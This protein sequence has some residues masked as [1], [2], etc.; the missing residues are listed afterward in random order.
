MLVARINPIIRSMNEEDLESIVQ[1]QAEAYSG[2]FLESSDVIATRFA[3]N[4]P[5]S[6]IAEV[7]GKPAAYLVSYFSLL[8]KINPLN[9]NF[10]MVDQPDCLYIHDLAILPS[11]QGMGIARYLLNVAQKLA[12]DNS[13]KNI[14]L[15]SVQNTRLF[16]GRLGF[17][18]VDNISSDQQKILKA[19]CD[20][21]QE[22]FYM[23][24]KVLI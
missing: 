23:T 24:K 6:W 13:C 7:D 4:P 5:T 15:L 16:W 9:K 10:V 22:A 18:V 20:D 14:A 2:Y 12:L 17:C 11:A 8:G 19:Y 3:T 1:I 21:E